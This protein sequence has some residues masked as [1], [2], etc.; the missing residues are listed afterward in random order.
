MSTMRLMLAMNL[1]STMSISDTGA[2][3]STS[4]VRSFRS[5]ATSRMV[6]S[7]PVSMNRTN[8]WKKTWTR[9]GWWLRNRLSVKL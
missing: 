7:G 8:I 6:M 5:S 4:S 9:L 1:A 3:S 2:V